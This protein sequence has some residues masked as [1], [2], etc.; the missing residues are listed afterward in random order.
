MET[1]GQPPEIAPGLESATATR[2]VEFLR[3]IGLEIRSGAIGGTTVL[4]GITVERG[5]IIFDPAKLKYPGDLLHEA[6]H[7]AVKAPAERQQVTADMSNDPAEEMMAIA[8][9]YAAAAHLQLA[10]DVVFHP[11]GYRG[12]SQSL[13]ENFAAGRYL[14][15][16]MLQW[17]G[18]ACDEQRANET[19]VAPYPKMIRW[20]RTSGTAPS[21][22]S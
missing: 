1:T 18:L 6:G 11:E 2:I 5:V 3:E 22:A 8:W 20:L 16:P 13:I 14:A 17:L 15:V 12:G 19:G 7:L 4:P 10:P 21:L 9:S